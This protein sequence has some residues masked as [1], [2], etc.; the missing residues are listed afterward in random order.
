[1]NVLVT[2]PGKENRLGGTLDKHITLQASNSDEKSLPGCLVPLLAGW[3]FLD[4][5]P[6][7]SYINPHVGDE[8]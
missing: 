5:A 7:K 3:Q 6:P 8:R 4:N 1:M 2:F